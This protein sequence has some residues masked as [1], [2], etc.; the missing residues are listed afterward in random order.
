MTTT[1]ASGETPTKRIYVGNLG[2]NV[3]T[4]DLTQLFGLGTTPYLKQTCKVE[5][6]LC[7]KTSKSKN[8]GFVTVPEH[9][10][11]ELMKLNGIEF[12]GRQLVIEEA[13]TKEDD[14]EN[15]KGRKRVG[16]KRGGK[17]GGNNR[18]WRPKNKFELPELDQDQIFRLIDGGVNLTNGKFHNNDKVASDLIIARARNAGIQ[19]MVVTGLQLTGVKQALI[20]AK[21]RPNLVYFAVGVHPHHVKAD[22][23]DKTLDDLEEMVKHPECVAVGEI[24]LD[25]KR[26]FTP[27]ELQETAFKKQLPLAIRYQKALIVHE[28]ESH[29]AIMDALK[30]FESSLPPVIIHCFTGTTEHIKAYVER[31]YYIGLTGYICK[32][33][34]ENVRQAI[35]DGTLPLNRIIVQS[36]AP[37]MRPSMQRDEIDPISKKILDHCYVENEPC[38]LSIT[39]RCIAKCLSQ[40]PRSVADALTETAVKVYRFSKADE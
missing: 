25:F 12:Y 37:W 9:V 7:E 2:P 8:F 28:R 30:E 22:W 15:N 32:E 13:K 29:E 34:G 10:H 31:G 16:N 35:K 17:K 33:Y 19:K 40:D 23:T 14:K 24:G 3:T 36:N 6:A 39:V 4:E 20:L 18:F 27:R 38:T 1:A 5:I 26:D 21:S 11:D